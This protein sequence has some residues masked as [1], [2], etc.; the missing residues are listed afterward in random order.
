[1][2]SHAGIFHA[3]LA[4]MRA[5][6]N[7]GPDKN[8]FK[9]IIGN[10]QIMG[11][12]AGGQRTWLV[13]RLLCSLKRSVRNTEEQSA[14]P[15]QGRAATE[16]VSRWR[17]CGA[18]CRERRAAARGGKEEG[19]LMASSRLKKKEGQR[20][21]AF[22]LYSNSGQCCD[23]KH[24]VSCSPRADNLSIHSFDIAAKSVG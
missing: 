9:P 12:D 18:R 10:C 1:M 20:N 19:C 5:R 4:R 17:G 7:G 13:I 8:Y 14:R 6:Q 23:N 11:G 24:L 21:Q 16:K 2:P 15:H 22:I 3:T